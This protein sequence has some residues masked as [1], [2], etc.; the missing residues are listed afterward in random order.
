[1]ACCLLKERLMCAKSPPSGLS[2]P[3][4]DRL[5]PGLLPVSDSSPRHGTGSGGPSCAPRHRADPTAAGS[6]A[7]CT[8]RGKRKLPLSSSGRPSI[9]ARATGT[10]LV[11]AVVQQTPAVCPG[12]GVPGSLV[13]G[14]VVDPGGSGGTEGA[15]SLVSDWGVTRVRERGTAD[16]HRLPALRGDAWREPG[17]LIQALRCR[18]HRLERG[19]WPSR[20]Q[21]TAIDSPTPSRGRPAPRHRALPLCRRTRS[22]ARA[23]QRQPA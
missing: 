4:A 3:S 20:S 1:M 21:T 6:V 18:D 16:F 19:L 15:A 14:D 13:G 12:S 2:M 10:G 5:L 8:R 23:T 11:P 17:W 7:D 9:R 22:R